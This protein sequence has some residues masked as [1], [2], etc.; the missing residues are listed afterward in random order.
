MSRFFRFPKTRNLLNRRRFIAGA[1][2]FFSNGTMALAQAPS[3]T[4]EDILAA[5][6]PLGDIVIGR[7]DAPLTLVQY[8]SASCS[9]SAK[10]QQEIIPGLNKTYIET[11]KL[12]LVFRELPQNDRVAAVTLLARCLPR[13]R[14]FDAYGSLFQSQDAWVSSQ[15][16]GPPITRIVTSFGMSKETFEKCLA[17]RQK[18]T[19]LK[20]FTR[21]TVRDFGIEAT[22][23]FFLNGQKIFGR[24]DMAELRTKLF[25]ATDAALKQQSQ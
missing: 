9:Y 19:Q 22:P 6:S 5:Q 13:E 3:A 21:K 17:D 24:I 7:R 2:L 4:A 14:Y 10:F 23:T 18:A 1:A 25:A 8:A 12:K 16:P 20:E 11:G 15:N